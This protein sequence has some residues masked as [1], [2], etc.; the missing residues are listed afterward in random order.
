MAARDGDCVDGLLAQLVSQL[1]QL[2]AVQLTQVRRRLDEV[3]EWRLG[4][5]RHGELHRQWGR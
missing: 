3:Q 4:R 1:V 5:L 2:A